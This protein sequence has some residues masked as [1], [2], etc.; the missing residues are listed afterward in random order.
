M[1][2]VHIHTMMKFRY[3]PFEEI[4]QV[5][6]GA[7][8]ETLCLF[9]TYQPPK[10]DFI[11]PQNSLYITTLAKSFDIVVV[12]T[13][14]RDAEIRHNF[15][16]N[17]RVVTMENLCYDFGLWF[18]FLRNLDV[19]SIQRI[20]LVN[21]SCTLLRPTQLTHILQ[22]THAPF[23]GM[24]DSHECG[25]HHVQSFFLVFENAGIHTLMEFV[26]DSDIETYV[27]K[28]KS[29]IVGGFEIGLSK[30]MAS[31]GVPL[32]AAFAYR[33]VFHT[34]SRWNTFAHNSPHG[35]WDR[36]LIAGMPILKRGRLHFE[37]EE[38]FIASFTE[39]STKA[40]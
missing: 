37:E 24:T 18:R 30:F 8:P 35:M 31:K 4:A 38:E 2:H 9:A 16:S 40:T 3:M 17:V 32:N 28:S 39:A 10:D 11:D 23:W 7:L 25:V 20:A 27:G 21:D 19:S 1:I 12:L 5:V 22:N 33:N 14:T 13:N 29:H 6:S 36:L 15:P 34:Q 26:R